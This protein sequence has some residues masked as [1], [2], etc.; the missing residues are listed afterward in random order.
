MNN[1]GKSSLHMVETNWDEI[2]QKIREHRLKRLRW[3]AVIVG[4]CVAA[5]IIYYVFMQ[6]RTYDDYKITE[7]VSRSDTSATHYIT[8]NEGFLKYSNDGAAYVSVSNTNIW[9][10]SYEMENP[11]VSICQSYA[12]IADRQGETIYVLDKE[13]CQGE[14]T[15][16]MPISKIEVAAQGTVAVLMEENGTG[17]LSLFNKNGEQ[18]A[19]GAIHVENGGTPM[20]IALSSDGK[21]LGVAVVDVSEGVAKTTLT[22]YN[23]SSTGQ[24]QI[25]NIVAQYAY[26]D[27]IIP[28]IAYVDDNTMLAFADNGVY[29]FAG[30]GVPKEDQKLEVTEEIQSIFYDDSYFGLAFV[31]ASKDT[32]RTIRIYDLK[33]REQ[34]AIQ[35]ELPYDTIQFLDNHE[36][37]LFNKKQC[38]IFTLGGLQKF[39]YQFED[40]I[41]GVFHDSGYRNYIIMKEGVTERVRFKL[42]GS[43]PSE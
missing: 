29:T 36:I 10:Q 30:S 13:D 27:T 32:G 17:Y 23:F 22:F 2:E 8:F 5:G 1:K 14:I 40:E 16:N 6:H 35:T 19:E 38:T 39:S 34:V 21:I 43:N 4:I 41:S 15:V 18:L 33:C 37:C 28:E 9:N 12:A 20:D 3:A 25:D 11:M 26:E 42:F 7:E 24:K 31:D